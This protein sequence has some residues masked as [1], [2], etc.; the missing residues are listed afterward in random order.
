MARAAR[1]VAATA[2]AILAGLVGWPGTGAAADGEIASEGPL[3]RIITTPDLNCQVAHRA[4]LSFEFYGGEVGACGTF[5]AVTGRVFGPASIPPIGTVATEVWQPVIQTPVTGSGSGGDPF[6]VV[7]VVEVVDL[8][9]R[10]EQTDSYRIGEESYRTDVRITNGGPAELRATLFRAGD[11]FLQDSDTGYGRVIDGAPACVISEASNARIEQWVPLTPGSQYLEDDFDAV[12][13]QVRA[14]VPFPNQCDCDVAV[15]NGG[16]LSWDLVIPVGASVDVSHLTFFSP[17]GRGAQVPLRASVPGPPE[18]SLD[19]VVLATSAAIAA[20]VVLVVPFPAA[21]FNS[22]LEEH[23]AEVMAFVRRLRDL[24]VRALRRLAGMLRS[25]LAGARS[26]RPG[27]TA[28]SDAAPA[29]MARAGITVDDA[30]WRSPRGILAFVLLS[31][32][33]YSLLDPTFGLSMDSV[34]TFVGLALGM[35]GVL[36]G[37]AI[38]LLIAARREGLRVGARALPGTLLIAVGCVLISRLADFQPGYLYGLIVGFT[39]S[40]TLAKAESGRLDA[41]AAGSTLGLAIVAWLLLPQVRAGSGA[42]FTGAVLE[43][44]LATLVVA[45]LEAASIAMLPLRFLPGERVRAWNLRAWAALLGV[46]TFGFCHIL[47]NPS[48]GYLADTTRT[49]LF[50]VVALLAAFGGGSVL[51]WAYFRFRPERPAI[52]PP[53]DQLA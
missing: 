49:S 35:A 44:A 1:L 14:G 18:V 22:T 21:L 39:F 28:P 24:A 31:A 45:G 29:G 48:S 7:T 40:R 34:A 25:A 3:T 50:T 9:I 41:V 36:L 42:G 30:F 52:P 16:G 27:T 6:R 2:V 38:P 17:E 13:R 11:C 4:D 23:Y 12:W 19:P 20:G 32:L 8:A 46:S 10:V 51:F 53:P 47:L 43:T 26:Q 15:D 5:L 33:L 37:F